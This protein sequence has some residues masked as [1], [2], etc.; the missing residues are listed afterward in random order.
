[1]VLRRD[2]Q[3]LWVTVKGSDPPPPPGD[4]SK[5]PEQVAGSPSLVDQLEATDGAVDELEGRM[6]V[7]IAGVEARVMNALAS[8]RTE[9][10][11]ELG[12]GRSLWS[13]L[14]TKQGSALAV[15]LAGLLLTTITTIV[16]AA[17]SSSASLPAQPAAAPTIVYVPALPPTGPH[18]APIA[19]ASAR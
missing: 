8:T 4:L 1:M 5:A 14:K 19:T 7:G 6:L 13:F 16:G 18:L 2:L 9:V 15:G 12:T 17:R 11:K 3:V 10:M